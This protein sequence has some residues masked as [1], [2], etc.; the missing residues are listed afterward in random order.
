MEMYF[1]KYIKILHNKG[2]A[3]MYKD[4]DEYTRVIHIRSE[5]AK[6]VRNPDYDLQINI[7]SWTDK[8]ENKTAD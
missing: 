7:M 1:S 3:H 4:L 6:R 5:F 2:G 8:I